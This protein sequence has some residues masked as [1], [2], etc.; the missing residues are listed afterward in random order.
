[1]RVAFYVRVSTQRQAQAQTIEQQLARLQAHCQQQSWPWKE[2]LIFRDDGYSGSSL[3]R[4]GLERLRDKAAQAAFEKILI[5]APDRLARNY[6]HQMLLVEELQKKGCQLEF[7]D[8]PMSSDPHDQ[9]LLQIRGAVAEY[10]RTLIAERMRRGRLQKYKTG[11][12]L[13]WTLAPYGYRLNPDHPRDPGGVSVEESEAAIVSEIFS[14]YLEQDHTL[15]GLARYLMGKGILTPKGNERWNPSSLRN[16]LTNPIYTGVVYANRHQCKPAQLRRSALQPVGPGW[17]S[18]VKPVEEWIEVAR[19]PPLVSQEQFE[20]VKGKLSQNQSF[21]SRNNKKH[22]YL[23]RA[24][25]SCGVC[26][27]ACSGRVTAEGYSYYWCR[28]RGPTIRS[29]RDKHCAGRYIPQVQLDELV[30]QDLRQVVEQ[31]SIIGEALSR[32]KGGEGLPQEL[33]ARRENLRK[34]IA[35][36]ANQLE[37]LTEAYLGGVLSL[38]EYKR[39][40]QDNEDRQ[41]GLKAQLREVEA[42]AQRQLELNGLLGNIEDFCKRIREGLAKAS[43]EQKRQLVELLIDRVIVT[44]GEVEIRYVIPTSPKSENQ[45]FCLL[46]TDYFNPK[47]FFVIPNGFLSQL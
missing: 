15:G 7:L 2:E 42:N 36:L 41:N 29:C 46:R 1:M 11:N 23:L 33:G 30:W 45:R 26:Q 22:Q 24:L 35:S 27:L 16:I 3:K 44:N 18:R 9:L 43:F 13:P 32:L 34:G 28:G 12:L 8:H 5:T 10:E 38:E 21:A 19:V 4:P 37:R 40:R 47:P 20:L 25:I 31:P 39:R 17:S 14:Y 6:V